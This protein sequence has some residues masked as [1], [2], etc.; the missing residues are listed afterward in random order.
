MQKR[1]KQSIKYETD[2]VLAAVKNKDADMLQSLYSEYSTRMRYGGGMIWQI[3]SIFIPLSL[4][5]IV[6]GLDD[7]LRVLAVGSFS[8]F[9]I[10]TWYFISVAID[11][12]LERDLAI[13]F[14]RDCL[15]NLEKKPLKRG[16][17][18]TNRIAG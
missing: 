18:N 8:V 17:P 1:K 12:A 14:D 11:N 15:L 4:S 7:F 10:W 13:R 5:G 6:L 9:L 3:G 2:D 16:Q